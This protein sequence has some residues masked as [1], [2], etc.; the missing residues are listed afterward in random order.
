VNED[1]V[2]YIMHS[3]G[4]QLPRSFGKKAGMCV[5]LSLVRSNE[6]DRYVMWV[7][8]REAVAIALSSVMSHDGTSKLRCSNLR[9]HGSTPSISW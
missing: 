3:G 8:Y 4:F 6:I 2:S 5:V 9:W 1:I 7:I